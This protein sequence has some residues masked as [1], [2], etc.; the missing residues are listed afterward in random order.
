MK[1]YA[2]H[3]TQITCDKCGF[4][5]RE[6]SESFLNFVSIKQW[7]SHTSKYA[8]LKQV[9]V[10]FCEDCAAEL[11]SDYW[12][13]SGV[14]PRTTLDDLLEKEEAKLSSNHTLHTTLKIT[15]QYSPGH[16]YKTNTNRIFVELPEEVIKDLNLTQ[17]DQ[18]KALHFCV[19]DALITVW[20]ENQ[21]TNGS[22][23]A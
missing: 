9:S 3:T 18:T 6:S 11:L 17:S 20:N 12:T 19:G 5:A 23:D 1:E 21:S 22:R 4:I 14:I 8:A 7:L 13:I 10:D 15:P 2:C 16:L